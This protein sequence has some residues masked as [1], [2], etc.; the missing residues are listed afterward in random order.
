MSEPPAEEEMRIDPARAQALISQLAS[1][2]DRVAALA[3]GR[4]V[5]ITVPFIH[6]RGSAATHVIYRLALFFLCHHD[7]CPPFFTL[8]VFPLTNAQVRLVAVSKLKPA[9][10]ILALHLDPARHAHFGENYAQELS[11]KADLLPRSIQ[12]HFIGG[13]QSGALA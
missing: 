3:G 5:S 4:N 1:V 11:Q 10:D 6:P 12:W 7:E 9:N 13:L 2:K 8:I